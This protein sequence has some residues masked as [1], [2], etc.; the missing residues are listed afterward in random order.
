MLPGTGLSTFSITIPGMLLKA[1]TCTWWNTASLLDFVLHSK[2]SRY[3]QVYSQTCSKLHF[4]FH[5]MTQFQPGWLCALKYA[6]KTLLCIHRSNYSDT[7]L[8]AQNMLGT[9]RGY[10]GGVWWV[11]FGRQQTAFSE[12]CVACGMW[13][14]AGDID[15]PIF[16]S[17][18]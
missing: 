6:C 14:V 8:T 13:Q 7:H 12:W 11:V 4:T 5:S 3:L 18:M 9:G 15:R 2:L 16:I 1:S 17:K 10:T